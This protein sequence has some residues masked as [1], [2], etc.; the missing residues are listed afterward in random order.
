[1]M[2]NQV[3]VW[4]D[5][6]QDGDFDDAGEK[7]LVTTA[8]K[9]PW[10]GSIAIPATAKIGQTRMRVRLHDSTL[11][12]NTTPCG[13]SGYGQVEDYTLNVGQLAVSDVKKNSVNVYPNPAKD[14]INISNVSSKAQFE[15]YSVGGQLVNQGITD[16]KV[17]VSK[18]TKGV[19][20]L[21]VESNGEKTQT[22]FIKN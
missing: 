12:P 19:Y 20:I 15:I 21:S 7:V 14:V 22:K 6:N 18:L 13:T 3:L 11:T 17:N 9:S 8:K 4:I 2:T 16:G 1:M 5:L 10:T